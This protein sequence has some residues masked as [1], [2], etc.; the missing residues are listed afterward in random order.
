M[1]NIENAKA[2]LEA[3]QVAADNCGVCDR[4]EAAAR[5][6]VDD[7]IFSLVFGLLPENIQAQVDQ[8]Y[9]VFPV[10]VSGLGDLDMDGIQNE[11]VTAS[12][13]MQNDLFNVV[14]K[15]LG[16]TQEDDTIPGTDTFVP[17]LQAVYS[18]LGDRVWPVLVD[19]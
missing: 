12:M 4:D 16:Y 2:A 15:K 18:A 1:K 3:L 9:I 11:E 14:Y 8:G 17:A 19:A 5:R 7:A 6:C 13:E 10:P